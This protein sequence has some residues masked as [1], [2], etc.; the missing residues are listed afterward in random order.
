MIRDELK[1]KYLDFK[2]KMVEIEEYMNEYEVRYI[3]KTKPL[4]QRPER[5]LGQN[6]YHYIQM[7]LFRSKSFY[8]GFINSVNTENALMCYLAVRAHFEVTGSIAYF[9]KKLQNFYDGKLSYEQLDETLQRL[10]LGT[11]DPLVIE[12]NKDRNV[13]KPINV[14]SLIDAADDLY[15]RLSGENTPIYRLTYDSLSEYCHPNF[16]GT[17]IGMHINSVAIARFDKSPV[18]LKEH[19]HVFFEASISLMSFF[20]HY[21]KVYKL[22]S[23]NEELPIII[24]E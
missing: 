19:L 6:G 24:K 1:N 4:P 8:E 3:P 15:K 7:I 17:T 13:P 14:M 23:E 5:L 2:D 12:T 10:W 11:H 22:L 21:D 20:S 9:Y 18:L 16:W